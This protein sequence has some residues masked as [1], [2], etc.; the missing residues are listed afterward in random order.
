MY[1][2]KRL[3][4]FLEEGEIIK[5]SGI[6]QPYSLFDETH[7]KATIIPLCCALVC[8]IIL[9]GGYYDYCVSKGI[10]IKEGALVFCALIPLVVAYR[11]VVGKNKVKNLLYA[12][13]DK[14]VVIV[15]KDSDKPCAMCI[16]DIDE[17]RSEKADNGNYHIRIGSPVF[18]AS[19]RKLPG[20]ACDGKFDA[21]D[22]NIIGLVF[23]NVSADDEKAVCDLLKPAIA[24]NRNNG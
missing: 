17:L 4:Q 2:N 20:L 24:M 23:Y 1:D 7:K 16:A 15:P 21:Q 13:T 12:V 11:I 19:A 10:D 9:A 6:A 5:W 8:A 3:N 22:T 18:K 14:R